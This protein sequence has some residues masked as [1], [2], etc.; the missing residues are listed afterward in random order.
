MKIEIWS[1]FMCPFCYIGKRRFEQALSGFEHKEEVEVVLRSFEL[2]PE[3]PH[4]TDHDVHEAIAVKYGMSREQARE[5]SLRITAQAAEV[6]L[7]YNM[8]SMVLTNSFDA[9][10]LVHFA[11]EY[12]KM[13]EMAERLFQA[14]FTRAESIG[15]REALASMAAEVG[16]SAAEAAEALR[17][18]RYEAEVRK[19]ESDGERLGIRG[20]PFFVINHKYGISGAQPEQ[21]FREALLKIWEEEHPLTLLNQEDMDP[22]SCVDGVCAPKKA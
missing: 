2:D 11:A 12:G 7:D 10:R 3:A 8:D 5:N 16:L 18:G 22:G 1:D 9:H 6:G 13:N 17:S 4:T 14:V 19:D 21:A 20:V 15:D